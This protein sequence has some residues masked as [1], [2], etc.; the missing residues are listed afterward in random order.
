MQHISKTVKENI[1]N[2][3][4]KYYKYLQFLFYHLLLFKEVI[5]RVLKK[6]TFFII[7]NYTEIQ[8]YV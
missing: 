1:L 3:F 7:F 4:V 2:Y 8:K 5:L 6:S